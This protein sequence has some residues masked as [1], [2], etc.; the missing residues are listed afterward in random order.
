MA[1]VSKEEIIEHFSTFGRVVKVDLPLDM[2]TS[3][4]LD[5]CFVHFSA[6]EELDAAVE[7]IE[8]ELDST[9]IQVDKSTSRTFTKSTHKIVAYPPV[10]ATVESI[11]VLFC[12]FGPIQSI[13]MKFCYVSSESPP[14][15]VAM[16]SFEE[17]HSAEHAA[18]LDDLVLDGEVVAVYKAPPYAGPVSAFHRKLFIEGLPP[19]A[20]EGQI[21]RAFE[22]FG[23]VRGVVIIKNPETDRLLD[24]CVVTF[25][26]NGVVDEVSRVKQH[27]IE[28]KEV[29]VRQTG[30]ISPYST[31][32][33]ELSG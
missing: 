10:N 14:R 3:Q 11:K 18:Q 22:R 9:I 26:H 15:P 21:A 29:R 4:R 2:K 19:G 1:H 17:D 6:P 27:Y 5:Y 23:E 32:V 33:Q 7:K 30:W 25:K 28:G 24:W 13:A 20:T 12:Q 8:Q 16:V 31:A